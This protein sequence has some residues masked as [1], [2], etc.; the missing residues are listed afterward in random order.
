MNTLKVLSFFSICLLFSACGLD[1]TMR[2]A[3]PSE[4]I[5]KPY[6]PSESIKN[7]YQNP[8]GLR[9]KQRDLPYFAEPDKC[10]AHCIYSDLYSNETKQ[11][12]EYTGTNYRAKGVKRKTVVYSEA[13]TRWEKGKPDPNCLSSN[14]EDCM[15]MCLIDVPA[16]KKTYY[17]VTDT[18]ANKEFKITE[19][20]IRKLIETG[21]K[22][23]WVEV[24]CEKDINY[25]KI[26]EVQQS[27]KDKG[28]DVGTIDGIMGGSIKAAIR[29]FQEDNGLP[30]GGALNI[31]T[32]EHLGVDNSSWE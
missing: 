11:I 32:L 8:R 30:V 13:T 25:I 27:L 4:N 14:P 5:R 20:K 6:D 22:S 12:L 21:G 1:W 17:V 29:K 23:G 26:R 16:V 2:E 28:Y 9:N 3:S 7:P 19:L 18:M 15:V 10:Y 24:L 31:P